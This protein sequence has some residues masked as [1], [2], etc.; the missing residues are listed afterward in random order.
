MQEFPL[1]GTTVVGENGLG[2]HKYMYF[3]FYQPLTAISKYGNLPKLL[4]ETDNYL[5]KYNILKSSL[6]K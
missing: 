1:S 6:V 2:W 3:I 5:K 4:L